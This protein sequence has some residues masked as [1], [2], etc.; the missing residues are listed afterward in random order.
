MKSRHGKRL[1]SSL[2]SAAVASGFLVFLQSAPAAA[3]DCSG[4]FEDVSTPVASTTFAWDVCSDGA[5]HIWSGTLRD[6]N[7]D[8]RSAHLKFTI[9]KR[10]R[11]SGASW[12]FMSGSSTYSV[13]G[14]G[15]WATYP[16]II[17]KRSSSSYGNYDFRMVSTIW[18]CSSLS[19]STYYDRAFSYSY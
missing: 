5:V 2:I 11:T 9:Q 10:A 4:P 18:A 17:L 13:N 19:C 16:E 14:C 15:N 8:N 7:C 1:F 6:T 12:T 3:A